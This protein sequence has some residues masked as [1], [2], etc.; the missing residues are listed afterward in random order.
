MIAVIVVNYRQIAA[1][2]ECLESLLVNA[3][4]PFELFVVDNAADSESRR[5]LAAFAGD[6]QRQGQA[7]TL[8]VNDDNLGF[9]AACNQALDPIL[10]DPR[11]DAVALLNNDT[12][13]ERDWLARIAAP[14]DPAGGIAMVACTMTDFERKDAV[15]SLG[16]V[17]YRSGIASNRKRPGDPLLGPCGGAGLYGTDMLRALRN[18][19]GH[20]FDPLFFCYAE[21][22]DL[23]LRARSLGYGCAFAA[24]A[25]VRHHGC[26]S[27]GGG[28]NEFVAYYGL[29]NSLLT[30]TKNMPLGF[31]LSNA[32][33]IALM[34]IAVVAKY[35]VKGRPGLVLRVYRDYLR[36]RSAIRRA[37]TD[38]TDRA[39][40]AAT[41]WRS[42]VCPRFYDR[43]YIV[44]GLRSLHRRDIR[45]AKPLI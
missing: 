44:A 16:I 9:A 32:F 24:D 45:P 20:V 17:F 38:A 33:W 3:G 5:A 4:R 28:F 21:D 1:T 27:S 30:L 8:F 35:L 18:R 34:Q 36:A 19:D 31:F 39:P 10:D 15:D 6:N 42:W 37:R 25:V 41:N 12:I 2:L 29:R 13:V 40:R 23:A 22:T 7:V 14:F 26:L 43:A 11:F